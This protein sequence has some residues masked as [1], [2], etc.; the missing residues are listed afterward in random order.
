MIATLIGIWLLFGA[1]VMWPVRSST[2]ER[3]L[4]LIVFC[5]AVAASFATVLVTRAGLWSPM[6]PFAL[7]GLSLVAGGG[8]TSVRRRGNTAART[9]LIVLY[10]ATVV[11]LLI[12][13]S[14]PSFETL[15][16]LQP[17]VVVAALLGALIPTFVV[18]RV[19]RI[20]AERGSHQGQAIALGT[21]AFFC[22][23]PVGILAGWLAH[24][25]LTG[26]G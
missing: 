17:A 10:S 2:R 3:S 20:Q 19:G 6:Y 14:G 18:H 15:L 16:Q 25:I 4:T 24:L 11:A 9:F 8:M 23:V 21:F 22:L 26:E 1:L 12:A 5:A 7:L 13:V